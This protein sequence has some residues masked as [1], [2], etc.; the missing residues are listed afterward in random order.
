MARKRYSRRPR[1]RNYRRTK[2]V[3]RKQALAPRINGKVSQPIHYFKR[4]IPFGAISS[5]I[6]TSETL[7]CL[8]LEPATDIPNWSEFVALYDS[9]KI[10]AIKVMFF[11]VADNT[12][13]VASQSESFLRLFT[14]IDYND[15]SVPTN[16]SALR[17][18][19]NCKVT[20]NNRIHKRYFKPNFTVDIESS[21]LSG[22]MTNR[23][24]PWLST[25]SGDVEHLAL[26]YGIET[27]NQSNVVALYRVEAKIYMAFK[28]KR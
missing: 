18:Y 8:F 5:A 26:K 28:S 7:G 19:E 15:R 22:I 12:T 21:A 20:A 17:E 25:S 3:M 27:L 2:K 23:N 16:I 4:W 1:K 9:Y 13:S 11:P 6:N 14:A 10:M 24:K